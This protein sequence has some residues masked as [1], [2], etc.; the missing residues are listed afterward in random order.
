MNGYRDYVEQIKAQLESAAKLPLGGMEP[1][2]VPE[3]PADAPKALIFSPHP[4]DECV[5]GLLPLRLMREAKMRIVNVAVTLGSNKARQEGRLEELKNACDFLGWEIIQTGDRGLDGV[6]ELTR[7]NDTGRWEKAVDVIADI[8]R[9]E[10]PHVVFTYHVDDKNTTHTGTHLLVMDALASMDDSF[11]CYVVETEFWGAMDAPNLMVEG[12][13]Q[14]VADLVAALTFHVEEVRR[15]PYH[16]SLPAWMQDNVRRGSEL[17]GAQGGAA[18]DFFFATL[19]RLR[20]WEA[21]S[22]RDVLDGGRLVSADQ[23]PGELFS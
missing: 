20:R 21:S 9:Q 16:L 3:I 4:D 5:T 12:D 14:I 10:M 7:Q 17:V 23:N 19:Y 6:N 15:N 18:A 1:C 13:E 8:L 11:S 22:L 2:A